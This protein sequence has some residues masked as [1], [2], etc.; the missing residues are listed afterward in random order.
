M[1]RNKLILIIFLLTFP[2]VNSFGTGQI[3]D[4]LIYK[5]D[6]LPI[7]ANPLE[8]L[9]DNDSLRPNFFG[10]NHGC[11]LTSCWRG[12]E[13]E[14]IIIDNQ[15][16]LT[17][18]F[19]CCF[20]EDSIKA[21][22]FK[23]FGRKLINGKVKADWFTANIIAGQGKKL[24]NVHFGYGPFYAKE[25]EL[26]F[27]NGQL[28]GTKT[29]NNS[30]SQQSIYSQD[31]EKLREYIYTNIN[32]TSL[33]KLDNKAIK[34]IVQFSANENGIIDSVKIRR[35]YDSIFDQEAIRVVNAIPEWEVFFRLE[36]HERISWVLPI[37]FCNDN[38]KKYNK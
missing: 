9:Y 6:T 5:G 30:K 19:S 24:Y 8:E 11:M 29:Y 4:R 25:L 37:I 22:L 17:G 3:P 26:Q 10:N 1:K 27:K 36:K 13:A 12:Y 18:I 7:F 20:Y 38:R 31:E 33:P 14:W 32:W 2:L 15:L 21:D 34:V 23:L 16:Y 28:I 35:G